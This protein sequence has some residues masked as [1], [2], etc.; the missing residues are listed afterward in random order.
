MRMSI[1]DRF[2]SKE[3]VGQKKKPHTP[4]KKIGSDLDESAAAAKALYPDES[5]IVEDFVWAIKDTRR[6]RRKKSM[7]GFL[8]PMNAEAK[9]FL[10]PNRMVAYA[11]LLPPENDGEELTLE[12]FLEEM[13]YEGITYGLLE[14]SIPG[15]FSQGY[16]HIFPVARGTLPQAGEDGSVVE[17]FQRR[18]RM[19][20]E[21]Q[22][23]SEVDFSEAGHLP[24]VRQGTVICRIIP[25]KPGTDGR[26]VTGATIPAPLVARAHVVCG[27][28]VTTG[29]NGQALV[30]A[31]DG[32]LYI[33]NDRFCIQKQRIIDGDLD[34]PQQSLR[35]LSSLY[36]NG[37]VD[38]GVYVE[39]DGDIVINGK[40]GKAKVFSS[41]G[42]VYIREGIYGT[43][44]ITSVAAAGQVQAAVIE[45]AQVKSGASVIT[46][47]IS[48][49]N[50]HCGGTVYAMTGRGMIASSQISAQNNI[51]CLR[52]GT[53]TGGVSR[54]SVGYP[55]DIQDR[56]LMIKQEIVESQAIVERLWDPVLTLRKKGRRITDE[57]AELLRELEEQR[58]M[59][60][61]H[62]ENLKAE[63]RTVNQMLDKPCDGRIR[64]EK[65]FPVLEVQFGRLSEKI[66]TVEEKCNIRVENGAILTHQI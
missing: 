41:G 37:N 1:F 45:W 21:V 56:W 5:K 29:E 39:A 59:H 49:S 24:P 4:A 30:A 48:N 35:V 44:G 19:R 11:C 16:F 6:I 64:C 17:L 58:N 42:T 53:V 2:F 25:P 13:H 36:I 66:I 12:D 31:A 9:F 34:Q 18:S 52:I 38:G 60:V 15:E 55:P 8:D 61:E 50:I 57:E 65:L 33:E 20:L 47:M 22:N 63:I 23:G 46:E 43:D 26:D 32:I 7:E 28:N 51:L 54:F 3:T 10:S 27:E 40:V 62:L 14:D